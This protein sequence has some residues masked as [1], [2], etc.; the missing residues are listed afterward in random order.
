M[1]YHTI[2]VE[3]DDHV[4]VMTLNRPDQLNTFSSEMGQEWNLAFKGFEEDD[5][6]RVIIVTGA[7][8][9]F[10]AGADMSGGGD[11]FDT[12]EDMSFS[13]CPVTPPWKLRKPV[14]AALNGHAVGVGF[15]LALQADIRVIAEEGKYGL[16]QV[17]RGVL[18]DC[19][20]HW[21][22]PKLIG[23][24]KALELI[25]SGKKLTG[26]EAYDY[27]LGAY[28]LPAEEVLGKA[29]ELAGEMASHCSPLTMGLAKD[30]I[31]QSAAMDIDE[32]EQLET[33]LLHH[34]MG[35]P[36]AIEGGM[37][38]FE[39]RQANWQSSVKKDWPEDF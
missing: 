18:A 33:R 4:A 36:D 13:S 11:T 34:T 10:C 31:W 21:V 23:M 5:S 7:G 22:L 12:Q 30:L 9:A 3:L 1:D 37:A 29:K 32:M 15:G 8:K 25:L 35:K 2:K 16:L 27:G 6:V 38:Y 39:K 26:R 20:S 24:E 28:C 17:R 19:C 14:I